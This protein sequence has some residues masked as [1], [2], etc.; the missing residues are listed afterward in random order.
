MTRTSWVVAACAL[1]GAAI[2]AGPVAAQPSAL[3]ARAGVAAPAPAPRAAPDT[4]YRN[5]AERTAAVALV[6]GLGWAGGAL[7]GSIASLGALC[8]TSECG[9]RDDL[10]RFRRGVAIGSTIGAALTLAPM[11]RIYPR[12]TFGQRLLRAGAAAAVVAAPT[13]LEAEGTMVLLP[14]QP[15]AG[16]IALRSCRP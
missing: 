8:H 14:L 13:M 1:L 9:G 12:C 11:R 16:M 7:G 3:A 6:T 10:G 4:T 15:V 5:A 2:A